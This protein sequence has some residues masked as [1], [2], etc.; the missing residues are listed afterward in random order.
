MR[1]RRRNKERK[2]ERKKGAK[3]KEELCL[4]NEDSQVEKKFKEKEKKNLKSCKEGE[5][6]KGDKKELFIKIKKVN[7]PG[8][9]L[10]FIDLNN[11]Y[12]KH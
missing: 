11:C 6:V 8:G 10:L 2:K 3:Q 12:N 9:V 7:L 4:G 1:R 5:K